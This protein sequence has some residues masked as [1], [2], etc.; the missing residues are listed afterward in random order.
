MISYFQVLSRHFQLE[1]IY[2]LKLILKIHKIIY[3]NFKPFMKSKNFY[4]VDH[5]FFHIDSGELCIKLRRF[6]FRVDLD[7]RVSRDFHVL[8]EAWNSKF[9]V[10]RLVSV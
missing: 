4:L 10:E 5:H 1:C 9:S 6:R 2:I 3:V 7:V 8:D